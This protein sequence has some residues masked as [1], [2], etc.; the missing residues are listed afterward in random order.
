MLSAPGGAVLLDLD[1]TV[2][3]RG[4]LLP[5]AAEAVDALRARGVR[6]R[7]LTDT[8]SQPPE[9]ILAELAALGLTVDADELFT[10]VAAAR[11][12][13][14]ADDARALLM[15]SAAVRPA[16]AAF[17]AERG[18][19]KPSH[20]V[21]GDCRDVLG[22]P[23]LD[24]AFRALRDGAELIALQRGRYFKRADGDHLDTGAIVAALEF[25]A[26]TTARVVGKPSAEF[27]ALAMR[28][29]GC[30]AARCVVVGDDATTDIAGG[31]AIGARTVQVRTGKYADQRAVRAAGGAARADDVIDSIV[32]LPGLLAAGT[33]VSEA[34]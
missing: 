13:L 15:V 5:G 2:H 26:D 10:P 22:Y 1:G 14:A 19:D 7:F 4:A 31:R 29:A 9:A 20:V 17:A 6:L 34:R 32:D 11:L 8:D 16:L 12:L 23:L 33:G 21:V 27:F 28:S 3:A 25:A 24:A 18:Q 30:E